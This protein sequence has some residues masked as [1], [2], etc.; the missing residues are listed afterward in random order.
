[1][2]LISSFMQFVLVVSFIKFYFV[3]FLKFH[4]DM[5]SSLDCNFSEFSLRNLICTYIFQYFIVD[6]VV[7]QG[8]IIYRVFFTVFMFPLSALS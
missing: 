3:T 4:Y 2:F 8:L 1:M 7:Q 6:Q 5:P